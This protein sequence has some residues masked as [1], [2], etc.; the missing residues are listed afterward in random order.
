MTEDIRPETRA[1]LKNMLR[2]IGK[3]IAFFDVETSGLPRPGGRSAQP[4][5]TQVACALGRVGNDGV[6]ETACFASYLR[7]PKGVRVDEGAAKVTGIDEGVCA[8][9][10]GDPKICLQAFR[11]IC[12][13]ADFM[14][15]HNARFDVG[16]LQNDLSR[17]GVEF[18]F[19]KN[20]ICTMIVSSGLCKLKPTNR[21]IAAGRG[22]QYK[23]PKL[24]EAHRILVGSEMEN[25]HDAMAD[26][27]G[28][29]R[30]YESILKVAIERKDGE[31]YT[32]S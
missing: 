28:C 9:L 1:E 4:Y 3:D 13:R 5:I 17:Y 32:A 31:G 22:G 16:A 15:A 19:I 2:T 24:E 7:L 23:S 18:G 11:S 29:M 6:R 20:T 8:D 26:V 10:G 30:V 21:M 14:V 27:R 12:M 25:A